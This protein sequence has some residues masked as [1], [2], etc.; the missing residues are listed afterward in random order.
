M[1]SDIVK[2]N[3]FFRKHKEIVLKKTYQLAVLSETDIIIFLCYRFQIIVYNKNYK[4][5]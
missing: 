3:K 1:L 2:R 4:E 5:V